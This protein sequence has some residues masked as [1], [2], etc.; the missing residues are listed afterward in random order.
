MD[1]FPPRGDF[2]NPRLTIALCVIFWP[3]ALHRFYLG[4]K[5]VGL[6][7][8]I[9]NLISLWAAFNIDQNLI[10]MGGL[11]F[12]YE[13]CTAHDRTQKHNLYVQGKTLSPPPLFP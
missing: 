7:Y 1:N 6:G 9:I 5:L 3:L 4:H 13:A 8:V 10:L 2:L 12:L 11:F